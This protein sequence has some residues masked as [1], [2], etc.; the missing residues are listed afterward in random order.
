VVPPLIVFG[1]V[2]VIG[3]HVNRH[4][5]C[6]WLLINIKAF[7]LQFAT[8]GANALRGDELRPEDVERP[9][10]SRLL[11]AD[12]ARNYRFYAS[13][14]VLCHSILV[15]LDL[16]P[17]QD[18]LSL[19]YSFF[20]RWEDTVYVDVPMVD[21]RMGPFVFSLV[22]NIDITFCRKTMIDIALFTREVPLE[23]LPRN[24]VC[25]TDCSELVPQLLT[26]TVVRILSD[27]QDE[28]EL[29]HLSDQNS[30]SGFGPNCVYAKALRFRF[31]LPKNLQASA[32]LMRL[33]FIII[34]LVGS[35]ELSPIALADAKAA[36]KRSKNK[37]A[38]LVQQKPGTPTP[39]SRQRS[40]DSL[41]T[42][43]K[44]SL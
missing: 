26:P 44:E 13:G 27:F 30:H 34:D 14:R 29:V 19:A 24:M 1:L 39:V 35:V 41:L 21:A 8:L 11:E 10:R 6:R 37:I 9:F 17:R 42:S 12:G 25:M 5:A 22:R 15:E 16:K 40:S 36:R 28:I 4:L 33:V 38:A 20:Y 31:K 7:Q 43:M 3:W 23:L 2:Y 32:K 18:L